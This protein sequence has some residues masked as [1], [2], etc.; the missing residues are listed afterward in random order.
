MSNVIV[1]GPP[2]SSYVRTA[3]L[4]LAEKG[5]AHDNRPVEHK[6]PSHLALHPWG[7]VPILEHDGFRLFE[8]SAITQYVDEV[9]AGPSLT[10]KNPRE[11]AL[12]NQWISAINAYVYGHTITGYA[13]KYIFPTDG[14]PNRDE[15]A[16]AVPALKHDLELLDAAYAKSEWIAGSALSLADLF[17][18][19]ILST[20]GV[21]PEGA[22]LLETNRNVRRALNALEKRPSWASVQPPP[23]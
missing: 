7:R 15:I 11:R 1:F 8:T 3:R 9:F 21:F 6:A 10:P 17:I 4:T 23:P 18:A 19:P 14:K 13:L 22:E 12:M 5:V 16:K 2:Q 20:I